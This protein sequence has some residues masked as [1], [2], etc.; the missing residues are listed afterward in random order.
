ME[1]LVFS[2]HETFPCKS[3]WLKKGFDFVSSNND[4]KDEMAV[5]HLGV[6]KNMVSSIRFWL[7]AFSITDLNDEINKDG[8]GWHLFKQGLDPY[9]E[10]HASLWLLHYFLVKTGRA[11]IYNLVFNDFRTERLEFVRE[12]LM[13]YLKRKCEE[14]S[15]GKQLFNEKTVANDIN[16]FFKNYLRPIK[17]TKNIE[18]DFSSLLID[19]N[20]LKAIRS[21]DEEIKNRYSIN[22]DDRENIP[23]QLVLFAI[24]DFSEESIISF[25]DLTT[26]PNSVGLVFAIATDGLYKKIQQIVEKRPEVHFDDQYGIREIR[27]SERPDKWEILR[28]Y[29]ASK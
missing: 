25:T 8:P 21:E 2:G 7:R 5:G 18:D 20:L 16:V 13:G 15:N 27:F 12:N 9:L 23:W 3:L 4:F 1:K 10:D 17:A 29:Y 14:N 28:S 19:L 24:L 11:S 22:N 6:G 26:K